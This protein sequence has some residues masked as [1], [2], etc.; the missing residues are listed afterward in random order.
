MVTSDG[1][2]GCSIVSARPLTYTLHCPPVFLLAPGVCLPSFIYW[3]RYH[4]SPSHIPKSNFRR[5]VV[6]H[7]PGRNQSPLNRGVAETPAPPRAVASIPPRLAP[8]PMPCPAS[9]VFFFRIF[10]CQLIFKP[11]VFIPCRRRQNKP[12]LRFGAVR[13]V[14]FCQHRQIRSTSAKIMLRKRGLFELAA[15]TRNAESANLVAPRS[16]LTEAAFSSRSTRQN[17]KEK[18]NR[19]ALPSTPVTSMKGF[20]AT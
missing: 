5:A 11:S 8:Q 7:F 12:R 19:K 16:P 6:S 9:F 2:W 1:V 17:K 18:K 3:V 20:L 4:P 15:R 13:T 14:F 10:F